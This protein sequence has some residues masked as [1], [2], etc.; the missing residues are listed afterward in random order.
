MSYGEKRRAKSRAAGRRDDTLAWI[1][2][3][4]GMTVTVTVAITTV[5]TVATP[6]AAGGSSKGIGL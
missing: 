3:A 6:G 2:A 5:V 1:G 4:T